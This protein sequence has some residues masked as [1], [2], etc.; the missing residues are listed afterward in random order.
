MPAY[1]SSIVCLLFFTSVNYFTLIT[2]AH[3]L[4]QAQLRV[5]ADVIRDKDT[6]LVNCEAPQSVSVRQCDF[7]IEGKPRSTKHPACQH[8]F[9]GAELRRWK[10]LIS[11]NITNIRV[12][13]KCW[14]TAHSDNSMSQHSETTSVTVW[15]STSNF[16]P[17]PKEF[18][19]FAVHVAMG[20]ASAV[21]V[22]L[23]GVTVLCLCRRHKKQTSQ[24]KQNTPVNDTN[25]ANLALTIGN[26]IQHEGDHVQ[27][28]HIYDVPSSFSLNTIYSSVH[29][30]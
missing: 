15:G 26:T 8:N 3:A 25:Y 19:L 27:A 6:V 28:D 14:Y 22:I 1:I 12:N 20:V 13:L 23:L 10:S 18:P 21:A 24:S 7:Y 17:G 2:K 9:T 11:T 5:S 29:F 4:P 30:R 16:T